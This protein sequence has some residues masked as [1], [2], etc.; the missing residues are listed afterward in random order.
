[1]QEEA[2]EPKRSHFRIAIVAPTSAATAASGGEW[3]EHALK[4]K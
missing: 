1:V 3:V 2:I 4:L